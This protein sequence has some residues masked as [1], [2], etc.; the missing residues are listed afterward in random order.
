MELGDSKNGGG[1]TKEAWD[2]GAPT[3]FIGKDGD[4][5][6]VAFSATISDNGGGKVRIT[7]IGSGEDFRDVLQGTLVNCIFTGDI[8]AD[9]IYEVI[10]NNPS[11]YNIIDIELA[12][13]NSNPVVD[14]Y[15]GGAF[16][17]LQN[18]FDNPVNDGATVGQDAAA[19]NRYIYVNGDR[20][21]N[22]SLGSDILISVPIDINT[23][24]GTT[25][26]NIIVEGYN[27]TLDTEAQV[28]IT[29]DQDIATLLNF[30]LGGNIFGIFR[31]LILDAAGANKAN[32]CVLGSGATDDKVV[33]ENCL[34]DDAEDIAAITVNG[35]F[36]QFIN[37]EIKES[38]GGIIMGGNDGTDLRV[39]CCSIHDNAGNGINIRA[40]RAV[41]LNN[42]IYDNT[43]IGIDI[44]GTT[45][46][47]H[48]I[49]GNTLYANDGDNVNIGVDANSN[50]I[51]NNAAV[52]SAG[53]FGFN[54][55][56]RSPYQLGFGYNL[57]AENNS[58]DIDAGDF[59]TAGI[60]SNQDSIQAAVDIFTDVTDGV[61]N[62]TPKAA[63][64][65]INN[66]LDA[67]IN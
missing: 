61:E 21:T 25:T 26:T 10:D 35:D 53:G 36:W 56:G 57:S 48:V 44:N 59:A 54:F 34:F 8:Y 1:A 52:G 67:G 51:M 63:G 62:F 49:F 23:H 37:C 14:C 39:I 12:Y 66:G 58:G 41:I 7:E 20:T 30:A 65:L 47:D 55:N 50:I 38:G 22:P 31:N 13:I 9:G 45:F 29:T 18:I 42:L 43:G 46:A 28:T 60:G 40:G 64:D 4:A 24:S 15:C 5:I 32:Q 16:G 3:D 2:A 33:F 6:A 27:V 17:D 11:D 19:H